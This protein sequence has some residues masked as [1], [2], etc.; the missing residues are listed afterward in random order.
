V[1]AVSLQKR[2]DAE[3]LALRLADAVLA[4]RFKWASP[5]VAD[6]RPDPP[7]PFKGGGTTGC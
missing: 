4:H 6:R 7:Q 5:G 2:P 1:A 3:A